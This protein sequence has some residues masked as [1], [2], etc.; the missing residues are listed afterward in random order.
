MFDIMHPGARERNPAFPNAPLGWSEQTAIDTARREGIELGEDHWTTIRALQDYFSRND[1]DEI[2]LRELHD[3]LA[4]RFHAKG[5]LR[6][7]YTLLPGGPIAQG[8][9]LAGI[10]PPAYAIDTNFGSVS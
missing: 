6:H 10:E 7:L 5:G 1:S 9:R 3:A 8:C 4:E 2:Q